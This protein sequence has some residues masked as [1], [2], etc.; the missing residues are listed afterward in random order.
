M[1]V[2]PGLRRLRQEEGDFQVSWGYIAR[3]CSVLFK[4]KKT[5]CLVP[6]CRIGQGLVL[7][8]LAV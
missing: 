4:K 3:L 5:L 1:L 8:T 7:Q 2:I 6:F